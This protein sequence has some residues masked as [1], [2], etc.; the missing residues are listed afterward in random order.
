M[1]RRHPLRMVFVAVLLKL[2]FSCVAPDEFLCEES[3]VKLQE[4]CPGFDV[5]QITC[6]RDYSCRWN[7]YGGRPTITERAASCL[8]DRSCAEIR[9]ANICTSLS[10]PN[11]RVPSDLRSS[12]QDK[13][14]EIACAR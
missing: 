10:D 3:T 1:Q 7:Q 12:V 11:A 13:V 8:L 9:A 5:A 14:E 6:E 2:A 4:C